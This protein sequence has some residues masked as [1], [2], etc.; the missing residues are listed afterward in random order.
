E[1]GLS[2]PRTG[3]GLAVHFMKTAPMNSMA[4]NVGGKT[5]HN[6]SKL[7]IDLIAGAQSGGKKG[8]EVSGNLLHAKIQHMRWLII[9]E[10]ENVSVELLEAVHRQV[11]DSTRGEGI[12][13][14]VDARAPKQFALF[15]G[16]NLV[17]LGD[18]WQIPPARTLSIAA[19][20]F[21]KRPA[22]VGRI[23]E[24]FWAEGL[25]RSATRRCAL[26]QSHRCSNPWWRS[27]LAEL[28]AGDLSDRMRDF[29]HG[30]PADAPGSWTPASPGS[31]E[32]SAGH[33]GC[34]KAKF[35]A[36]WSSEWPRMFG[37]CR[38][39]QDMR[40]L[41]CADSGA[42]RRRCCR[43][44]SHSDARQRE[45]STAFA[46]ALFAHP[47][48]AQGSKEPLAHARQN[49]LM[50][51]ENTTGGVPDVLPIFEGMRVRF[52]TTENAEAGACKRS[53]GTVT[54]WALNPADS[55]LVNEHRSEPEL[56][57]QRAPDAIMVKIPGS[58]VP[59][60]G[61]Q[62][63]GVFPVKLKQVSWDRSPGFKATVKRAGPPLAPHFAAAAHCVAGS[64]LPRAIIDL[65]D[66]RTTPRSSMA[67][68]VNV[69]IGRAR[70]ADDLIITQPFPPML[71]RQG[72]R[73]A[74]WLLRP[75]AAGE[76]TTEQA[77]AGRAKA[78]KEA[79]SMSPEKSVDAAF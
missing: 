57:M 52:A 64:T 33:L 44:A 18:L 53:W 36:L 26:T 65:L 9:D 24:M 54:G 68:T 31:A 77:K 49:L 60:F 43:V 50:Y 46:D 58:T 27:F 11:K 61:N 47:Y 73:A 76:T 25:P 67:P 35:R 59:R 42:E 23:L 41:E 7:G 51:P 12:P 10:V 69:A 5:I 19:N 75:R 1:A 2:P 16:L 71:F 38:P 40:S 55:K 63:A 74:P 6:F 62:P 78:Q 21:V 22:N 29:V 34:G 28:R 66:T 30:F 3:W 79:A 37:E 72:H 32:A 14:A 13:W 17:L 56:V 15:G 39:W 20:P 45:V 8:P 48:N 4:S 70:R